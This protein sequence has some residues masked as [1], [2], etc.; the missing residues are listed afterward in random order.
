MLSC[1]PFFSMKGRE[2]CMSPY[3]S[4]EAQAS[5]SEG[6]FPE[7]SSSTELASGI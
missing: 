4:S 2:V 7:S 1:N 5:P 6:P 3:A